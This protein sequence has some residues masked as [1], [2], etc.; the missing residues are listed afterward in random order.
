MALRRSLRWTP[1]APF[2]RVQIVGGAAGA[3]M[4]NVMFD[5]PGVTLP[6][7][8]RGGTAQ[9]LAEAVATVTLLAAVLGGLAFAPAAIPR[10]VGLT[11]TA[12]YWFTP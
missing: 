8:V 3:V 2:M 4:A 9:F 1:Q 10:L 7:T 5:L 11:I 6:D 12:A